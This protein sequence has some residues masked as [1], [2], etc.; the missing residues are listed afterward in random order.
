[1]D[2]QKLTEL[3][4]LQG[5]EIKK[6]TP[7][8]PGGHEI[9]AYLEGKLDHA[10]SVRCEHHLANCSYCMARTTVLIRLHKNGDDVQIPDSLMAAAE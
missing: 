2:Q 1:M 6:S 8:C 10:D 4:R 7:F 3:L 5:T 9:A